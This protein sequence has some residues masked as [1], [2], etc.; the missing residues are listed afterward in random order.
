MSDYGRNRFNLESIEQDIPKLRHKVQLYFKDNYCRIEVFLWFM[1]RGFEMN[2]ECAIKNIKTII[3]KQ[4]LN[5][6][7]YEIVV[8]WNEYRGC[9]AVELCSRT[10]FVVDTIKRYFPGTVS[11]TD[12]VRKKREGTYE[13]IVEYLEVCSNIKIR[14]R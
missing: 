8:H 2:V 14:R 13:H 11:V 5:V 12:E 10:N 3:M 1:S 9:L 4:H 7:K 6:E